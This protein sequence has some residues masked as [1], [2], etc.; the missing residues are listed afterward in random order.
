MDDKLKEDKRMEIIEHI[1]KNSEQVLRLRN[2]LKN[3]GF[4][5]PITTKEQAN[6]FLQLIAQFNI[7]CERDV[8]RLRLSAQEQAENLEI[9]NTE[10]KRINDEIRSINIS[11]GELDNLDQESGDEKELR[12]RQIKATVFGDEELEAEWDERVQRFYS[13]R[14][15]GLPAK[16]ISKETGE[17]REIEFSSMEEYEQ[18]AED[19]KF[20]NLEDYNKYLRITTMCD[21]AEERYGEGAGL[22]LFKSVVDFSEPDFDEYHDL[23][24]SD[25]DKADQWLQ[26]YIGQK[27]EYV[28]TFHGFTNEHAVKAET[29]RTAGST[30]KYMKPV[31]GDLPITTRMGNAVENVLRFFLIR[32]PEFSKVNQNGEKVKTTGRGILTLA[33]DAAVI[34]GVAATAILAPAALPAIGIGYA[35]RGVV[36]I[37]NKVRGRI[38]YKKHKDVIDANL[39]TLGH[40]TSTDKEIIRKTYYRDKIKEEKGKLN[41]L[42]VIS[43]WR[44]AAITDRIT[45]WGRKRARE[46]EQKIVDER[47]ALSNAVIDE[48]TNAV[49][50]NAKNNLQIAEQNQIT[51]QENTR[52]EAMTDRTYNDIV[53]DPDSINID[54]T[55][56]KVARNAVVRANRQDKYND[57]SENVNPNSTVNTEHKYLKENPE[58]KQTQNLG[59][60]SNKGGTIANTAIT[61]EQKYTSRKVRQDRVNRVWTMVL[62][63]LG[64]VGLDYALTG[65]KKDVTI[66]EPKKI[67]TQEKQPDQ[68]KWVEGGSHEEPVHDVKITKEFGT[69]DIS[70]GADS[71]IGLNDVYDFGGQISKGARKLDVD[72]VALRIKDANGKTIGDASFAESATNLRALGE[73]VPQVFSKDGSIDISHLSYPEIGEVLKATNPTQFKRY[74]DSI[75]LDEN[76]SMDEIMKVAIERGDLF[77]QTKV[78]E[79]W[80][81][82]LPANLKEKIEEVIVDTMNVKN[83]GHYE[84]IP[85]GFKD[86][87]KTVYENHTDHVFD[88]TLL[89]DSALEGLAAGTGITMA[90]SLHEAIQPTRRVDEGTFEERNPYFFISKIASKQAEKLKQQRREQENR[91]QD[92]NEER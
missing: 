28:K 42:D 89:R 82:V 43:S 72:A 63:T 60:V 79:G 84:T 46:T 61:E 66:K 3:K 51:R 87:V 64:K 74:L 77:T 35:A 13:H 10:I 24:A 75:G 83:P 69:D 73:K 70:K 18:F 54:E 76:A 86:V 8:T 36:T 4:L 1:R 67:T 12:A 33:T 49:R 81:Q 21:S 78:L 41:I 85:G 31:K 38:E 27:K 57:F 22:D 30:L 32:K 53:K 71:D 65:F 6:E 20:L 23:L 48:R 90:D 56:G 7:E 47:I 68:Q 39:P 34:G 29:W 52:K 92:D 80:R 11:K 16:Y 15:D 17:E 50:I 5:N 25:P 44:K 88:P 37:A 40:S 55:L 45:P 19:T 2:E 9:F 14:R 26:N 62:S 91:N 58:M 59:D